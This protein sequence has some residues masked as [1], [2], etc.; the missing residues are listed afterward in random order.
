L[1]ASGEGTIIVHGFAS[2]EGDSAFNEALSCARANTA[3]RVIADALGGTALSTIVL[4]QH[5]ARPGE[6]I[7]RRSVVVEWPAPEPPT[8]EP[9]PT[10][11]PEPEPAP[12]PAGCPTWQ[13][14][15]GSDRA[16]LLADIVDCLCLGIKIVDLFDDVIS[17]APLVGS[18]VADDRVQAAISLADCLCGVFNFA[19]LAWDLGRDPGPCW[20]WSHYDGADLAR[21]AAMAAAVG[22]DC[23]AGPLS[24][25]LTSWIQEVTAEL[26]AEL[27]LAGGPEAAAAGLF[28]GFVIGGYLEESAQEA[29]ELVFDVGAEIAQNYITTGTPLPLNACRACT[30]LAG[31]VSAAVDLTFCD[32]WNAAIVPE[33]LRIPEFHGPAG[34][35]AA[36]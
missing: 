8:P 3:A 31:R 27:F 11:T 14:W 6:R 19:Q 24:R 21:L 22:I 20:H 35:A 33:A 4:F 5:G 25:L 18:I 36:P 17:K 9:T 10:P 34:G 29:L 13:E 2:E 1:V 23:G 7:P 16:A 28:L 32:R 30:R 15:L 12:E 26:A